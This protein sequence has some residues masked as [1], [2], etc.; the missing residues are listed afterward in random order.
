[1]LPSEHPLVCS[2]RKKEIDKNT[3]LLRGSLPA[4]PFSLILCCCGSHS[5]LIS[6]TVFVA[7]KK[8]KNR[9]TLLGC[10]LPESRGPVVDKCPVGTE[11]DLVGVH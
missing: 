2:G 6:A 8:K 4:P 5:M 3:K 1:M 10:A 7:K 11:W 9:V